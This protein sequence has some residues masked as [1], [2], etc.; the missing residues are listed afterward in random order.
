MGRRMRGE[1]AYRGDQMGRREGLREICGRT[2]LP[3]GQPRRL[4]DQ[5]T[6]DDR[7]R[8]T[9]TGRRRADHVES[10]SIREEDVTDDQHEWLLDDEGEAVS[11]RCRRNDPIADPAQQALVRHGQIRVVLDDQDAPDVRR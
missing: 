1:V 10:V 9:R 3:R 5:S 7:S 4:R 8:A 6:D 11:A 2:G